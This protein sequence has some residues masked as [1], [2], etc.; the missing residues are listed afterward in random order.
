MQPGARYFD[1]KPPWICSVARRVSSMMRRQRKHWSPALIFTGAIV[2]VHDI[3]TSD[4]RPN[5]AIDALRMKPSIALR[6]PQAWCHPVGCEMCGN[7]AGMS[8]SAGFTAPL[9]SAGR[10]AVEETLAGVGKKADS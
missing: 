4:A 1:V 5:M 7:Q 10:C 2:A 3:R 8:G 9:P 6:Q